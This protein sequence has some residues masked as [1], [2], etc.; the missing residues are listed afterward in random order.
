MSV[1]PT[2]SAAETVM[3]PLARIPT[4]EGAQTRPDPRRRGPDYVAAIFEQAA[5]GDLRFAP[6][7]AVRRR[8]E[9]LARG[10]ASIALS[11]PATLG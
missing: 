3:V 10:T 11:P 7:A 4:E 9:L 2:R 5:Q 6:V 8:P 1:T